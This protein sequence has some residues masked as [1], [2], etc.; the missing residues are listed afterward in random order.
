MRVA[1]VDSISELSRP[2]RATSCPTVAR[3]RARAVPQLPAPSTAARLLPDAIT[4]HCSGSPGRVGWPA[5]ASRLA[6]ALLRDGSGMLTGLHS[7]QERR[8]AAD[9]GEGET[10]MRILHLG[11]LVAGGALVLGVATTPA[12]AQRN[13]TAARYTAVAVDMNSPSPGLG[14]GQVNLVV[15]RWSDAEDETRLMDVLV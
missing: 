11:S 4:G 15:N 2:Q 14:A 6:R 7:G 1:A 3:C 9:E 13:E 12:F 8:S 10:I 5:A